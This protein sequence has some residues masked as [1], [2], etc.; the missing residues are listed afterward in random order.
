[1]CLTPEEIKHLQECE[2]PGCAMCADLVERITL[3]E[4][5]EDEESSDED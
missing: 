3:E 1:M 2:R 4:G 5:E